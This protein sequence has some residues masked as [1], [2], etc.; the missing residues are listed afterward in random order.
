MLDCTA[1]G[2]SKRRSPAIY[3]LAT[4]KLGLE[5][6]DVLVFEDNYYALITAVDAGYDVVGIYDDANA[7]NKEKIK[8]ICVDY[9]ND[10]TEMMP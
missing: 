10:Y 9:L 1:V 2:V 5:K 4:E 8:E 3:D 6:Q 7:S